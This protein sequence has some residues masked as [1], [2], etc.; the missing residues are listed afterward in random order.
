MNILSDFK[1]RLNASV[2]ESDKDQQI[3]NLSDII[4]EKNKIIE[5]YEAELKKM[6]TTNRKKSITPDTKKKI[7]AKSTNSLKLSNAT[8]RNE[9][10]K[11]VSKGKSK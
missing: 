8:T 11:T 10:K 1:L 5:K 4:E 7:S 9:Q 3:A 6:K 2:P